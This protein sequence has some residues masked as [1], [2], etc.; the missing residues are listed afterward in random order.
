MSRRIRIGPLTLECLPPRD[1]LVRPDADPGP[2]VRA[3][4]ALGRL[5]TPDTWALAGG[6]VV[7]ISVGGF[8]RRHTDI[9]IVMP[10]AR[11]DEVVSAFRRN[12]Y[13]L[14]T[15]WA[16]SHHSR[17]ILLQCRVRS[18]GAMLRLRP[19]RLYVKRTGPA[20]GSP[21]L[22]KIDLYPYRERDGY[23]ETCNT[24][25]KLARRTMQRSSLR[26]FDIPGQVTC[27]HLDNVASLKSFR[28]GAKHRLDCA[29]I[30]DG[31]D[32]AREWFRKMDI[33]PSRI[34]APSVRN[35]AA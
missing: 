2:Y 29:V 34:V 6:L 23:L 22:E 14:Y 31:P 32:A 18:D 24:R 25:R 19:R 8:Y 3:V 27:L 10:L 1:A 4:E 7:P 17:G 26:P 35:D 11:L 13:Q 5:L 16:A 12:G 15:N 28:T 21:L 9:D 33:T 30:R 20:R